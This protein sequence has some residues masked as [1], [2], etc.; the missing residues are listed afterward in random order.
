MSR[1]STT[2]DRGLR[3]HGFTP[4]DLLVRLPTHGISTHP[5]EVLREDYLPDLGWTAKELATRLRLPQDQVT[6]LLAEREHVTPE[7]ALR[8]G[9]LFGQSPALWFKR[10]LAHN[11]HAAFTSADED[12]GR[13]RPAF[14]EPRRHEASPPTRGSRVSPVRPLRLHGFTPNDLMVHLPAHGKA[15]HPGEVL[16]EDYLPQLG[17]TAADLA[18]RLRVEVTVAEDLL[19]EKARVTPELALRLAKLFRQPPRVWI[20]MQLGSDYC[21]AFRAADKDLERIE[22]IPDPREVDGVEPEPLRKAS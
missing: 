20:L 19:A 2:T 14:V 4:Q 21:D 1:S 13:I 11:Y 5:G 12:L 22:T 16:R 7:L 6:A 9:K 17:W 18:R 3:L 15:R 8:L 10:Q